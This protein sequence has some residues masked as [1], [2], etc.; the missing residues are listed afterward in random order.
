MSVRRWTERSIVGDSRYIHMEKESVVCCALILSLYNGLGCLAI[1][2]HCFGNG[3]WLNDGSSIM[4]RERWARRVYWHVLFAMRRSVRNLTLLHGREFWEELIS[5]FVSMFLH[6]GLVNKTRTI[7]RYII[8][9]VKTIIMLGA[10]FGRTLCGCA[11][12]QQ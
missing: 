1:W 10:V 8:I 9:G 11:M 12:R 3:F 4:D 6:C 7:R 2:T 5:A